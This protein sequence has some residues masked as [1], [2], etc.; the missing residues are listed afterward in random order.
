MSQTKTNI[1]TL[2]QEVT[3]SEEDIKLEIVIESISYEDADLGDADDNVAEDDSHG[4]C[5]VNV[6]KFEECPDSKY[7]STDKNNIRNESEQKCN[8]YEHSAMTLSDL[9][10]HKK[11]HTGSNLKGLEKQNVNYTRKKPYTCQ[12][13]ASSF[14]DQTTLRLHCRIHTGEKPHIC[15]ICNKSFSQP[16]NLRRH[17]LIHT[18]E[19]PHTSQICDSSFSQ[20]CS[21]RRHNRI[22]TGE[23][24]FKCNVCGYAT[25][26]GSTL[27]LHKMKHTGEKPHKCKICNYSSIGRKSL[28]VH[29]MKHTG[30]KS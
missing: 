2:K 11:S 27:K 23:K 12:I 15:Q 21:L 13:C 1:E 28:K 8:I 20:A 10:E 22:H 24:P 3:F 18:G 14:C 7:C 19:K 6:E 25:I 4:Q 29:M 26:E 9:K 16:G 30:E 5:Y 17:F